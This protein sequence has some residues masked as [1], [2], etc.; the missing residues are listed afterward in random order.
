MA[1]ELGGVGTHMVNGKPPSLNSV[2]LDAFRGIAALIV[3]A[4]HARGLF[5]GS[6]VTAA[7]AAGPMAHMAKAMPTPLT[8]G[9]EAV[10]VFFVL[11]GY[12]VGGSVLRQVGT[13]RWSWKDYLIKRLSR[14]W[15]VLIPVLFIGLGL[16]V[17]GHGFFTHAGSLYA[18]PAGQDYVTS[19]TFSTQMTLST[20]VGNIFFLQAI[21]VPTAGT[22]MALWSL[23]YEFWYYMAF[24]FIVMFFA[25]NSSILNRTLSLITVLAI[26]W[27]IR[28]YA[29][30]L[31][32]FWIAGAIVA[33]LP[34]KK[35]FKYSRVIAFTSFCL[36]LGAFFYVR[37]FDINLHL[38]EFVV[39]SVFAL[40]LYTIKFTKNMT[41][42]PI[43]SAVT[44]FFSK[45]S[46]TLYVSHV[47]LIIFIANT[48]NNP[49]SLH[50]MTYFLFLAFLGVLI[51]T[52]LWAALLNWLFESRTAKLR[53]LMHRIIDGRSPG[54]YAA[55]VS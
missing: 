15:A 47:P 9:H 22:N 23:A 31:F 14:L 21:R 4:G 54:L 24:P 52:I 27:L 20:L 7:F 46:Y 43:F 44:Q 16:D 33:I 55:H 38:A 6:M 41:S 53:N 32:I 40:L 18:V 50:H 36:F 8:I 11:S 17:V 28:Q 2:M 51:S 42:I 39:S 10:M 26:F 19:S 34:D 1:T 13:D 12:L 48:I 29:S 5:F 49:W 45:I 3:V 37:I 30:Y 35:D 25:K